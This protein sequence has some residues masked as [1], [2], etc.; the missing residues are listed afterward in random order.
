MKTAHILM[1]AI[2]G[3]VTLFAI[4][5]R[6]RRYSMRPFSEWVE[7]AQKMPERTS[8]AAG[9]L[10]N[11]LRGVSGPEEEPSVTTSKDTPIAELPAYAKKVVVFRSPLG[12]LKATPSGILYS[13]SQLITSWEKFKIT[14][15][16]E[17]AGAFD[18]ISNA[19]YYVVSDPSGSVSVGANVP[20]SWSSWQL[21]SMGGDKYAIRSFHGKY[22]SPHS[23]GSTDAVDSMALDDSIFHV[24]QLS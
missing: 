19:G 11:S 20:N 13:N 15:S 16:K 10:W 23:D 2:A 6:H 9:T 8:A 14:P 17:V 22:L 5:R 4:S 3:A 24:V 12:Y 1:L 18:I 21:E 7:S